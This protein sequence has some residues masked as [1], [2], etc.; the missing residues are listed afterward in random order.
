MAAAHIPSPNDALGG[1]SVLLVGILQCLLIIII[2][3][4]RI[5]YATAVAADALADLPCNTPAVLFQ[6]LSSCVYLSPGGYSA[7]LLRRE[8]YRISDRYLQLASVVV[9]EQAY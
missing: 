4:D 1:H 9:A 3:P 5:L 7:V 8:P 2:A 6:A